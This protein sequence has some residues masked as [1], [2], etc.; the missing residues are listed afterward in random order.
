MVMAAMFLAKNRAG[1]KSE[2]EIAG[3]S[4]PDQRWR[5]TEGSAGL[6]MQPSCLLAHH[7]LNPLHNHPDPFFCLT[8]VIA[9]FLPRLQMEALIRAPSRSQG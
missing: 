2:L 9:N 5:R 4:A 6:P 7:L 8:V 1:T 3:G